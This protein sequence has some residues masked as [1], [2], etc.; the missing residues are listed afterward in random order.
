MAL[1]VEL[2]GLCP[3]G[4]GSIPAED[5]RKDE[6]T[7]EAGKRVVELLKKNQRPHD[8]VTRKSFD[9]AIAGVVASGGSTNAVLHL[10][11][12]A[13]EAGI[14]LSIDDFDAASRKTPL[15]ADLKP[16][17]RYM[18]VDFDRAGGTP[19]FARRLIEA[20][21]FDGSARTADGQTWSEHTQHAREKPEQLVIRPPGAALSATGGLVILRG[22]LAP[23]GAVLKVSG[24]GRRLHRGPARVFEREEDAFA[25][26][27][28]GRIAANDV[29]VIRY[30]GPRGGPGMREMLGVTAAVVGR[31]LG[32]TVAL[33]TDGRFS[34]ATRG[35]MIGH[36]APEAAVGG[37]LAAVREGDVI[38]IDVN[39]R[40]MDVELPA[41]ELAARL[42]G[43]TPP[44][45]RYKSGV[46]A[47]YAAQVSSASDGAVTVP[48]SPSAVNEQSKNRSSPQWQ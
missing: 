27:R 7:R 40:R 25:A 6:A 39:A 24:A 22:N 48:V 41:G 35:F 46:F 36:V 28:D 13:R 18:A 14:P 33:V 30:E 4:Y 17:G 31:G 19:L 10:V 32:E 43:F 45:P 15:L 47:K 21:C 38:S 8:V 37:P 3:A 23:D 44:P 9:N 1:A 42:R 34:G 2:L 5:P 16:S 11:A 29:V 26:V 20:G 12:I